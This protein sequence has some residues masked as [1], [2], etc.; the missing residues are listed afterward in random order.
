MGE[1]TTRA[2]V[3]FSGALA[4]SFGAVL[5]D[6]GLVARPLETP[7]PRLDWGPT[8]ELGIG[9]RADLPA[10]LS[11]GGA[12]VARA[13]LAGLDTQ[14][15]ELASELLASAAW[16]APRPTAGPAATLSAGAGA[17][18]QGGVGVPTWR[19][20]ATAT[21]SDAI[22][23]GP[24]TAPPPVAAVERP[25]PDAVALLVE[26]IPGVT[27]VPPPPP[28]PVVRVDGD[29]IAF[30][31][32]IAFEP[33]SADL[34]PE[35]HAIIAATADLLASDGRIA[36]LAI[37][38]H[39]D[40]L[41]DLAADWDLSDR[42]GRA[43]WEALVLEGVSPERMSWRGVG[44]TIPPPD[45]TAGATAGTPRASDRR[46]VLLVPRRLAQGEA[47]PVTPATTLLP[48]NGEA[49][50]LDAVAIPEF[51]A[52]PPPSEIVDP[53]FFQEEDE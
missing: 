43:V 32:E 46:V 36:H 20:F 23:R 50:A 19:A 3:G 40:D 37:E 41:G 17:G 26:E 16:D 35:S 28:P 1:R 34:L 38:G 7:E 30:R 49:V 52:P 24:R 31:E 12:W 39:A 48:W 9:V 10:H 8:G 2:A 44:A 22:R 4:G 21:F 15:G 11:V 27:D 45:A 6:V 13:V 5:L 14:D 29:G 47:L 18:L 51:T 53:T 42:R 33:G 25:P